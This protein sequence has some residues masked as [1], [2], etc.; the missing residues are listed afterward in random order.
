MPVTKPE[1]PKMVEREIRKTK[2]FLGSEAATTLMTDLASLKA[3]RNLGI[4]SKEKLKAFGLDKED[5]S[6]TLVSGSSPRVFLI[7]DNT[8]GNLDLYLKDKSDGRVYIV[9]PQS[10]QDLRYAEYR[11]I[12]RELHAFK[13][14]DIDRVEVT[15]DKTNKTLLQGERRIPEKAFWASPTAPSQAVE[16]YGNWMQKVTRL[17]ALDYE[18]STSAVSDLKKVM[19]IKYF[20]GNR[21]MGFIRLF[22]G[23]ETTQADPGSPTSARTTSQ[24]F[25]VESE[26]TRGRAKI[27]KTLAEDVIKDLVTLFKK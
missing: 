25:F 22:N 9:R 12:E 23:K 20:N 18:S 15:D 19:E 24:E 5:K 1:P 16:V 27:S 10:I 8:Y 26:H 21:A 7:G 11:L 3:I 13:M 6:I 2:S 4:L 17:K 14:E